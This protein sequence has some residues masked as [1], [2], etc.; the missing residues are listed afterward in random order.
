M[1]Q[2]RE[3]AH[4]EN[5]VEQLRRCLAFDDDVLLAEDVG[6]LVIDRPAS[7]AVEQLAVIGAAWLVGVEAGEIILGLRARRRQRVVTPEL[8]YADEGWPGLVL[9]AF[10]KAEVVMVAPEGCAVG[11]ELAVA[12]RPV[13]LGL[14]A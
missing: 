5:C 12:L 1:V 13:T 9:V 10:G 2:S 4:H 7:C 14:L 11:D 8:G 6:V 3:A